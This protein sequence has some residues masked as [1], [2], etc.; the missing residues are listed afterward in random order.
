MELPKDLGTKIFKGCGC[1][2]IG[3]VVLLIALVAWAISLP[4]EEDSDEK[5]EAQKTEQAEK[6][7][8]LRTRCAR[9]QTS[10]SCRSNA[11]RRD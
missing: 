2:S 11:R 8:R 6:K 7:D 5:K 10:L 4:D 3:I 9:L 1:V